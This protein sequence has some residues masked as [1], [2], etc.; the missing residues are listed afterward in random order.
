MYLKVIVSLIYTGWTI[1]DPY[2]RILKGWSFVE[3]GKFR[4]YVQKAINAGNAESSIQSD[5][6]EFVSGN[7]CNTFDGSGHVPFS[8]FAIGF[9]CEFS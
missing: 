5:N 2:W 3:L 7:S 6:N 8:M 4:L 1:F 9:D